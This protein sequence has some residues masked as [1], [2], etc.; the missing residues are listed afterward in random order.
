MCLTL[1]QLVAAGPGDLVEPVGGSCLGHRGGGG[2]GV[3]EL[4]R[5]CS[6]L[7][8]ES[9]EVRGVTFSA[10]ETLEPGEL[11]RVRGRPDDVDQVGELGQVDASLADGEGEVV[12]E[13]L[14][15]GGVDPVGEFCHD[16]RLRRWDGGRYW[17]SPR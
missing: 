5:R 7:G 2:R 10:D 11:L 6:R 12:V 13:L 4:R 8:G 15:A 14:T 3:V 1:G 16:S 17:F 9:L